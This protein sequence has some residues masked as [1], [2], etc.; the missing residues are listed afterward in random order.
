M[1]SLAYYARTA[2]SFA[3]LM[4]DG[5]EKG[6]ELVMIVVSLKFYRRWD[7]KLQYSRPHIVEGTVVCLAVRCV[8]TIGRRTDTNHPIMSS[9]ADE[10]DTSIFKSGRSFQKEID[11]DEPS[12]SHHSSRGRLCKQFHQPGC[13]C[14]KPSHREVSFLSFELTG[15]RNDI[16]ISH[17]SQ[18]N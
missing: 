15:L 17:F 4:A 16:L 18:V 2:D 5:E 11:N 9:D 14:W 3:S 10:R 7:R 1:I 6:R 12:S 8:M 13:L